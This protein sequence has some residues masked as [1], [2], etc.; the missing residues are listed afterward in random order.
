MFVSKKKYQLVL[1]RYELA[2][3]RAD[4][5]ELTLEQL[6]GM[7]L[8]NGGLHKCILEC[9]E[10]AMAVTQPGRESANLTRD[11]LAF[12]DRRL[13][14]LLPLLTQQMPD[15]ERLIWNDMLESRS[16]AMAYGPELQL[17]EEE[18]L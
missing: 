14:D 2:A 16:A 8:E 3:S 12:I 10:A 1:T 5:A 11:R 6:Y 4:Q 7:A 17:P 13:S 18:T 15:R 9:R